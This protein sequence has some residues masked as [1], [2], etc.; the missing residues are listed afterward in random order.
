MWSFWSSL[1]GSCWFLPS[2]FYPVPSSLFRLPRSDRGRVIGLSLTPIVT[3]REKSQ[4]GGNT[5]AHTLEP[6]AAAT[7]EAPG[8]CSTV[9]TR[10]IGFQ[11][12]IYSSAPG[13]IYLSH[14]RIARWW[15]EWRGACA[16]LRT[17]G[18]RIMWV[19]AVT[20]CHHFFPLLAVCWW[21]RWQIGGVL[22]V[23]PQVF[24]ICS[25]L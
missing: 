6:T 18:T 16:P 9:Q 19:F 21:M 24:T 20:S 1:L 11:L 12:F 15:T 5:H 8:R 25:N 14:F 4:R 10:Q 23:V 22:E 13:F 7:V 3:W 17:S 2:Q